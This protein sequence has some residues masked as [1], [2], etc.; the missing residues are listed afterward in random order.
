VDESLPDVGI[1]GS[2]PP[3]RDSGVDAFDAHETFVR[4][5]P[6]DVE[7]PPCG[8]DDHPGDECCMVRQDCEKT[9]TCEYN[10]DVGHNTCSLKPP[11]TAARGEPCAK[12]P[13]EPG[14]FCYNYR[15]SAACCPG[16][17]SPCGA[18]GA[19]NLAI[20]DAT[21]KAVL[22]H[23]CSY[24][25]GCSPF[26]YD[27]PKGQDCY[28][29][30]APDIFR[31]H[32]PTFTGPDVVPGTACKY[33]NDCGESQA[34]F[35]MTTDAGVSTSMCYTFCWLTKPSG[36]TPGST[37]DG[38]FPADGTCTIGGIDYGKCT[39]VTGIGGGL[40]VCIK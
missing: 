2:T 13:C 1:D 34:C 7:P 21:T 23:L 17:D 14:L 22:Y 38:R 35:V 29:D 27:C 5:P 4:D 36:F 32:A 39:S 15:C 28:Y 3:P 11:G 16:D 24:T 33:V 12:T 9:F 40:G 8:C 30:S 19:C 31:C 6:R 18:G 26:E 37:P 20:T 10:P 25:D